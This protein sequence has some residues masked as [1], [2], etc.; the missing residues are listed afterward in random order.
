[1]K[2]VFGIAVGGFT[3]LES[4]APYKLL[5]QVNAEIIPPYLV[6]FPEIY[7]PLGPM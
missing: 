5:N 1:M 7:F 3:V 2:N 6:P 4:M